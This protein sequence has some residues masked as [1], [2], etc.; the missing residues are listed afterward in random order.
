M[1]TSVQE[2]PAPSAEAPAIGQPPA[3]GDAD[4]LC[5]STTQGAAAAQQRDPPKQENPFVPELHSGR[6]SRRNRGARGAAGQSS[7]VADAEGA[8]AASRVEFP[9]S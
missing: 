5:W 1:A 9:A 4:E 3:R 2:G 7:R 8:S 6:S